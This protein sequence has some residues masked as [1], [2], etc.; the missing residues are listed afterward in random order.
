MIAPMVRSILGEQRVDYELIEHPPSSSAILSAAGSHV[1]SS[2]VAKAVLLAGSDG[3]LLAVVPS[4]LRVALS[5]LGG[6]AGQRPRLAREDEVEAAF[7]DCAPGAIPPFGSGY[8]IPMLV[9]DSLRAEPDI[10]FES[11][12]HLSLVHVDRDGFAR[13]TREA[14]RGRIS[15]PWPDDS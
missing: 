2:R 10:Y 11:G 6:E 8:G 1:P 4:N 14:R 9:D 12:D 15:E 7:P 5:E 13:L 3:Y